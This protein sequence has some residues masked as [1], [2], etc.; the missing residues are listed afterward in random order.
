MPF[1]IPRASED[2]IAPRDG[3]DLDISRGSP[4]WLHN[5]KAIQFLW[6]K[7]DAAILGMWKYL[8]HS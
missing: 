8:C 1:Q 5:S 7:G 4:V 6:L 2:Q 3:P